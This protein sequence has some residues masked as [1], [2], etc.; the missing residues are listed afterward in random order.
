MYICLN[1]NYISACE[2][3]DFVVSFVPPLSGFLPLWGER[4]NRGGLCHLFGERSAVGQQL[5]CTPSYPL[6]ELKDLRS[7]TSGICFYVILQKQGTFGR[8]A[9]ILAY[10]YRVTRLN[11]YYRYTFVS[12]KTGLS[13][14]LRCRIATSS[15]SGGFL[16]MEVNQIPAALRAVLRPFEANSRIKRMILNRQG[17]PSASLRVCEG[18]QNFIMSFRDP[19]L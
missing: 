10:R 14:T 18:T 16:A 19:S 15:A 7:E 9:C 1:S 8:P 6:G 3:Q 11:V 4:A 13:T 5:F 2:P 12:L 17:A